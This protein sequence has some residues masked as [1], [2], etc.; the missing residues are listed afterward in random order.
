M[1]YHETIV[2]GREIIGARCETSMVVARLAGVGLVVIA[3][4]A[5]VVVF[6]ET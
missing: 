3:S 4:F 1:V 6:L 2:A 5:D